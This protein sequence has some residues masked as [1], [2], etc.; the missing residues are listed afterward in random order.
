MNILAFDTSTRMLAVGIKRDDN[1]AF[2]LTGDESR[3]A[4]ALFPLIEACLGAAALPPGQID[5]IA[6]AK[7]P[8]SFMGLRIGMAAAKGFSLARALPW[9]GV[10]TLDFLARAYSDSTADAFVAPVIDAKKGRVYTAFYYKG[11]RASEYLDISPLELAA[12]A[13][14]RGNVLFA[15]PDAELMEPYAESAKDFRFA[16][17]LPAAELDALAMLAFEAYSRGEKMD[18][19]EEPLYLREPEIGES[20]R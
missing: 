12:L 15:G 17:R 2:V 6:C 4:E 7:G 16:P 8:G 13:E 14:K 19:E 9:I 5:L 10:P 3:H 11:S 20:K 18:E 1:P